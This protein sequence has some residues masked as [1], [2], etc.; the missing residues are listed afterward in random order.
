MSFE[1]ET[2]PAREVGWELGAG[3]GSLAGKRTRSEQLPAST[4]PSGAMPGAASEAAAGLGDPDAV[5]RLHLDAASAGREAAPVQ[6]RAAGTPKVQRKASYDPRDGDL[7]LQRVLAVGSLDAVTRT[8]RALKK[9]RSVRSHADPDPR[10]ERVETT[11]EP[12]V[13]DLDVDG[14]AATYLVAPRSTDSMIRVLEIRLHELLGMV[15]DPKWAAF[16]RELH[17]EF[18]TVV[19]AFDLVDEAKD[20]QPNDVAAIRLQY[21]FTDEQRALLMG[22][23]RDHLIPEGLFNGDHRGHT[24]AQQ[25]ILMSAHILAT[26]KYRPGS[27]DQEVHA[28][29]CYHW[30]RIVHH[31]AGAT[32]RG[33]GNGLTGNFDHG[34]NA[35]LATAHTTEVV[36][37]TRDD[38]LDVPDGSHQDQKHGERAWRYGVVAWATVQAME[39]GDWLYVYNANGSISGAHSLIFGGWEGAADTDDKGRHFRAARVFDQGRP[40]D[41]GRSR[42]TLLGSDIFML[43]DRPVTPVSQITRV[44][45]DAMP[46]ETVDDLTPEITGKVSRQNRQFIRKLG[47]K[48]G[49]GEKAF[50]VAAMNAWLR[51]DSAAHIA[52]LVAADRLTD[53][54]RDLLTEAAATDDNHTLVCLDQRV[55]QLAANSAALARNERA[56]YDVKDEQHEAADAKREAQVEAVMAE[57]QPLQIEADGIEHALMPLEAT[58][59]AL[60]AGPEIKE[61]HREWRALRKQRKAL[62]ASDEAGRAASLALEEAVQERIAALQDHQR[63]HKQD[64]KELRRAIKSLTAEERRLS[65]RVDRLLARLA[66]DD[67]TAEIY[68]LVHGGSRRGTIKEPI[69]GAYAE[70]PGVVPWTTFMLERAAET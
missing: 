4:A 8:I 19:H 13:V 69:N 3:G 63:E 20:G 55:A 52:A 30:A 29:A 35:V 22:F 68:G 67:P 48:K 61:A 27:F 26:G 39:P 41:G 47:W 18:A 31:Y 12:D 42:T 40:K 9:A 36:H 70:I 45:P 5:Y 28:L 16:A 14:V 21:L 62:P 1:R 6:L 2:S 50:D 59:D 32:S 46:A 33:L 57:V 53:G 10:T 56:A 65:I 58:L 23:F 54:Q 51:T 15:P 66:K 7:A 25:R 17:R 38:G 11:A 49:M 44:N 37:A 64:I 34:G 24:T 60:D 43:G